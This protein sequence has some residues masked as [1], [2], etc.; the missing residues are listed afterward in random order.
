MTKSGWRYYI[1]FCFGVFVKKYFNQ[2]VSV[3]NNAQVM[4]IIIVSFP[5]FVTHFLVKI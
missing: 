1:F 4:A 3:T 2:F 5:D